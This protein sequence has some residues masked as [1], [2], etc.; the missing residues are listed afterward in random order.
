MGEEALGSEDLY[1]GD[2]Q[3]RME[4]ALCSY[5]WLRSGEQTILAQAR[6]TTGMRWALANGGHGL[7]PGLERPLWVAPVP[8]GYR[9]I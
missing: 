9:V 4:R 2:K 8:E 7:L 6:M 3:K 1:E 5:P